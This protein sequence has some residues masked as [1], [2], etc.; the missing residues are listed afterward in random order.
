MVFLYAFLSTS[1][2]LRHGHTAH[3][4]SFSYFLL[5]FVSRSRLNGTDVCCRS[6]CVYL[7]WLEKKY[8]N[9]TI[10]IYIMFKNAS[11]CIHY[12]SAVTHIQARAER[13]AY[14]LISINS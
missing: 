3:G 2:L 7:T 6:A 12:T 5:C 1:T 14:A 9:Y 11:N 13:Q 8:L 4:L 10:H